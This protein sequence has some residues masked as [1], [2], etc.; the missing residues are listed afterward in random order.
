MAGICRRGERVH[1]A[2]REPSETTVAEARLLFLLQDV[3]EVEPELFARLPGLLQDPQ[4]DQLF[5]RWGPSRNSAD[6]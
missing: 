4:V 1:V 6:R 2:G 3:L 5:T